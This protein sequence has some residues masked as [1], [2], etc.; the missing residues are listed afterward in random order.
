MKNTITEFRLTFFMEISR[1]LDRFLVILSY[2]TLKR[3][4]EIFS[5]LVV[6]LYYFYGDQLKRKN[7]NIQKTG[8]ILP[9]LNRSLKQ[10]S[11][12]ERLKGYSGERCFETRDTT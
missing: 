5:Y 10:N 11:V 4:E 12:H 3:Q 6:C 2:E 1:I 7:I 8:R 9:F